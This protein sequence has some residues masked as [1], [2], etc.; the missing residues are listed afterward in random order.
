[1]PKQLTYTKT[2]RQTDRKMS[3]QTNKWAHNVQYIPTHR[4]TKIIK[5]IF[6]PFTL[7]FL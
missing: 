6:D 1:M 7:N 5:E 3:T 4:T 2:D